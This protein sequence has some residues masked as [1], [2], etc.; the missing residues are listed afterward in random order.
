MQNNRQREI[1]DLGGNK[2]SDKTNTEIVDE[3]LETYYER[4][5]ESPMVRNLKKRLKEDEIDQ[6]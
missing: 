2:P 4:G 1:E 6:A 3:A 5:E